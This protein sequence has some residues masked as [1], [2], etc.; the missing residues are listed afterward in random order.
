[1][2][3]YLFTLV[4][5]PWSRLSRMFSPIPVRN[6]SKFLVPLSQTQ[7]QQRSAGRSTYEPSPTWY[8]SLVTV[9][10]GPA[11]AWPGWWRSPSGTTGW[12]SRWMGDG[13]QPGW[14]T[15]CSISLTD[16]VHPWVVIQSGI[17]HVPHCW[18]IHLWYMAN[19]DDMCIST[20]I[21]RLTLLEGPR[22]TSPVEIIKQVLHLS[23]HI[24]EVL[25]AISDLVRWHEGWSIH[26][27]AEQAEVLRVMVVVGQPKFLDLP[28]G[29]LGQVITA[30]FALDLMSKAGSCAAHT[31][32]SS[33]SVT[34]VRLSTQV[35]VQLLAFVYIY[36]GIKQFWVH[37]TSLILQ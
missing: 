4:Q 34:A 21:S 2:H 10:C 5:P 35:N 24:P 22:H 3:E 27:A 1:M 28:P 12:P 26:H 11:S 20:F 23:W 9:Q 19:M 33:N 8:V 6:S 30:S 13:V 17:V 16:V 15:C 31:T 37:S 32:A 14:R 25:Y 7:S 29:A 36:D 18:W